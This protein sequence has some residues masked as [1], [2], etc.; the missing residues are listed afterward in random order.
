MNQKIK[1]ISALFLIGGLLLVSGCGCKQKT[2]TNYKVSLEV[3]GILDDG[4]A[5]QGIFDN[6]K[7]INPNVSNIVYKKF[8][9][10]TYQQELTN[11][12]A[13]GNGPDIFVI[14]NTWLPSYKD[15]LVPI[16]T[17][18]SNPQILNVKKFQDNFVDVA[19]E[20]FIDKK[21]IYAVPLSVDSLALYYNKDLLNQAGITAPP[22][23]WSDFESDVQKMTK[24]DSFGNITQS[25]AAI[26]TAYNINRSTDIL[27]LLMLQEGTQMTDDNDLPSFDSYVTN[28]NGQSVSPGQ[29]ALN[30]YTQ[31]AQVGS[32][33][34]TWNP[35]L[36]YSVDA[37]SQGTAAMMLN[38]SWQA[39]TINSE[40]PKLN[41]GVTPVP[42]FPNGSKAD[43]ANYWG[44]AVAKNKIPASSS[45]GATTAAPT[46]TD[47][48]RVTEAWKL[49]TYLTTKPDG[50]FTGASS[51]GVGQQ[52]N[53][54]LDPAAKYL[55]ATNMPAARRDLIQTQ[56]N[57]PEMAPFAAGN[58]IDKSWE[59]SNP[60]SIEAIFASM[61]D[62]V[63]KG[64]TDTSDAI[65]AAA[66]RVRQLSSS[67]PVSNQ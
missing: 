47:A 2:G 40:A 38:Y 44:Y 63:N 65:Q 42:Q 11:A 16:P 54:G 66:Q 12:L 15:K 6:Y 48:E 39:A 18:N 32:L 26:G 35:T 31:F 29:A 10:D 34:Y 23:T 50:T 19:A 7:K 43:Y 9:V 67:N 46:A 55:Q 58:L 64:Q 45:Y 24:V 41:Y 62:Q 49:L 30:F 36:H 1:I 25:G 59:E 8:D 57:D 37:F 22:A 5:L 51:G 4:T 60:N 27:N 52:V 33:D 3:W 28:Q 17:D 13:A 61:I 14:N 56:L 53:N 20:D 21:Q